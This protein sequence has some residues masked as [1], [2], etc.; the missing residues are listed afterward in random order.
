MIRVVYLSPPC[1]L[2]T[3]FLRRGVRAR[4]CKI[5]GFDRL[6]IDTTFSRG[7]LAVKVRILIY[8]FYSPEDIKYTSSSGL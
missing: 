8:F 6:G 2:G 4:Q 7:M 3:V 5:R 1:I